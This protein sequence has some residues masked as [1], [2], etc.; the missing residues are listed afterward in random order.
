MKRR[1]ASGVVGATALALLVAGCG[2]DDGGT[3]TELKSKSC[4]PI[5]DGSAKG[6][7][8]T[9]WIM[10]GTNAD[11]KPFFAELGKDFKEQTGATLDV[12][13]Q[14]W[15]SVQTKL[16]NA[17]AGGTTPDVAE[18]GTTYTPSFAEAGAL[19][20]LDECV[21][22]AGVRDDLVDGLVEAGT[23]DDNLY[24]MPWYAGVRSMIYRTDVFKKAGL[25]PP[26]TWD[27]FVDVCE[28]LKKA[29]PDMVPF[30]VAGDNEFAAYPFIWGAD[31]K[32]ATEDGGQWTSQIDSDQARKG[33]SFYTE[34]AT[35]HDFSTAAATTWDATD[36][37]DSFSRGESAMILAGNWA[38]AAMVEAN[39]DLKGKIGAFPIPGPD[40]G[41]SPSF[42]GGSHLSI[43]NNAK[44][45]ELAWTFVHMMTS[46]KYAEKWGEQ[47]GFFPGTEPLLDKVMA[48]SDPLVSP[49]VKQMSEA[50]ATVPVTPL[51][52]KVQGKE[53]I[54]AMLQNILSGKMSVDE[55]TSQAA[56]EMDTVFQ[57]GS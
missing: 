4:A 50:G 32:V 15:E 54:N 52:E 36:V 14:E 35:D 29:E 13:Y 10:E 25:K 24:G 21:D 16:N 44:N 28:K 39:P 47:T 22:E 45:P 40:G 11:S 17:I 26:T 34:L 12:Q 19:V 6:D 31:G 9:V 27:E 48:E 33:L 7:Q 3:T 55:A 1:I 51:Y 30:P 53:T 5:T 37:T 23:Y 8:L 18:L 46:G 2:G 43:F 42:L 56:D 41:I 57:S 49:F 20:D 38:P